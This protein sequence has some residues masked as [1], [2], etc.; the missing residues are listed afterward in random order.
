MSLA[1]RCLKDSVMPIQLKEVSGPREMQ[2]FIRLPLR[3][4]AGDPLYVPHLLSERK[5]F[6]DTAKN[7]LFEFTEAK[8][9]LALDEAGKPVGRISAHVNRRHNDYWEEKAGF[10]GFFECVERPE[11][12]QQLFGAA[13]QWLAAQ[14]MTVVRGPFNFSTNEE[15]G[16]LVEGFDYPPALMMP[17]NPPYYADLISALGYRRAKD[18]LAYY[19]DS[20]GETPAYLSRFSARVQA[21]L[22]ITVRTLDR[23]RFEEEVRTAF[24]VYNQAWAANWGFV[25]MTEAEFAYMARA[26]KPI[27]DPSLVLIAEVEGKPVGFSVALPDYNPVLKSMNGRLFPFGI[28]RFLLGRRR[29]SSL[30]VITM[31]V[32]EE[33]R[34]RGVD[35]LL[36]Y[37][38]FRNGIARGLPRGEF[39]WVLEDNVMLVRALERMGAERRKTYRIYEKE[40]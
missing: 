22:P 25:P 27:V 6:F 33:H 5:E 15:C 34:R 39:S 37:H 16:L 31:G 21:R 38:T 9:F 29:L 32:V 1:F 24:G 10:F 4:Y 3:L 8:Y 12:A 18:L 23:S 7:P 40:L 35:I 14:G 28:F 20:R 26:L 2:A 30:R 36:I 11:A 19:H 13:E 17:Y